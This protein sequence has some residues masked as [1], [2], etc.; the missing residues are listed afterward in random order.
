MTKE[1]F[2]GIVLPMKRRKYVRWEVV[3]ASFYEV[4]IRVWPQNNSYST[5]PTDIWFEFELPKD[6][7]NRSL[8]STAKYTHMSGTLTPHVWHKFIATD[9]EFKRAKAAAIQVVATER[10]RYYKR[11]GHNAFP[12]MR[13][14]IPK[15]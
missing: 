5:N 9:R 15:L 11:Y 10:K 2:P 7:K 14:A 8:R 1:D 3:T 13:L 12:P 4:V 6:G